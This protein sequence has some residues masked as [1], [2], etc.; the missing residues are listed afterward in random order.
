MSN[1]VKNQIKSD[2]DT[3]W[4][5]DEDS[6]ELKTEKHEFESSFQGFK[7]LYEL[8]RGIQTGTVQDEFNWMYPKQ[9]L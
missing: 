9:G 4:N 8:Y 1:I 3:L 2:I 7:Q 6:I 5:D